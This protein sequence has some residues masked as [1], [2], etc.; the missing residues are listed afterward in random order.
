MNAEEIPFKPTKT[1]HMII[2]FILAI[3]ISAVVV[4]F[5]FIMVLAGFFAQMAAYPVR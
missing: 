1:A 2:F 3:I 5:V 4:F